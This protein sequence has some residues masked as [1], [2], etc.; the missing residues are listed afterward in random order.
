[1]PPRDVAVYVDGGVAGEEWARD[2]DGMGRHVKAD[3]L[4]L[5]PGGLPPGGRV[6][7][8]GCGSGRLLRHLLAEAERTEIHGCDIDAAS[9]AWVQ[10]HLCP[11]CHAVLCGPQPPLPHPD[12]HFD[13]VLAVAVFSQ[14]AE[15]WESWLLE[16]RRVLRPGGLFVAS[17]MGPWNGEVI[18]GEPVD[19]A[20]IGMS[21]HGFGR[22]WPAGGPMILHSEWWLRAHYGRAFDVVAFAPRGLGNMDGLIMRR[23]ERPAPSPAELAAPEPG[24][25]RELRAAL[26]DVE[27]LHREY[28]AL[29]AAHDAY[30][31]AY[32]QLVQRASDLEA[33][34][35]AGRLA[36]RSREVIRRSRRLIAHRRP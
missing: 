6:L 26:A 35:P 11:P 33:R 22:R 20:E 30:A 13:V 19:E 28:A 9:I 8:F 32:A 7:D 14:L 3:L 27:R 12:G 25:E 15:G 23:P 5:L 21:V 31:E 36:R 2:F 4:R 34:G 16:L 24:E 18:A 10:R 29:N 1:M 17:L